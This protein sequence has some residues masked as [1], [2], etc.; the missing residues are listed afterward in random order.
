[1]QRHA[2]AFGTAWAR[3][4]EVLAGAI[5]CLQGRRSAVAARGRFAK[6]LRRACDG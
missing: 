1:L 3:D 6:V 4:R 2:T 5:G